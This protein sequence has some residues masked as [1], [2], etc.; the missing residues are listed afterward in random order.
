MKVVGGQ[1]SK[2]AMSSGR[3]ILTVFILAIIFYLPSSIFHLPSVVC[4]AAEYSATETK[5]IRFIREVYNDS[6]D[7]Q[8]RLNAM[9][10]QWKENVKLKNITFMRV[11]DANGDGI[12]A[13]EIDTRAGRSK[14][15]QVPFRVFVK[16]K[17]F[18]LKIAGKKDEAVRKGDV[19]IKETYMNGKGDE[20]PVSVEDLAGKVL[21]RDVPANTIITYQMLV[22]PVTVK[23]GDIVNII[24]EN[25]KLLVSAKGKTIDK[26][27]IGDTV[28]VK[29]ISSGK[30]IIGRVVAHNTIAVDF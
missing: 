11:P 4:R 3:K 22:D 7:I 27:G 12:C 16:R 28:R 14:N 20:Y 8:V 21:K 25:K 30:E 18:V 17:L 13:V 5:I 26:G 29:N 19:L 15:V 1:E 23:R 6:D 2:K 9:P 10:N 24:V